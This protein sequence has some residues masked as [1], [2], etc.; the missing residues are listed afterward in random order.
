MKSILYSVCI[1]SF[2]LALTAWGEQVKE[3]R[4]ERAKPQQRTANVHA[5]RLA[6]TGAKMGA[7]QYNSTAQYRQRSY[8]APRTNSN[9]VA[10]RNARLQAMRERNFARNQE[11]RAR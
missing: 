9:F 6:N 10:N 5:A 8:T 2:A 7:R 4:A 1:G 11:F 3:R